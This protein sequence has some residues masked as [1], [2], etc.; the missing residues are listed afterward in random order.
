MKYN[1]GLFGSHNSA[2]AIAVDGEVKEVVEL[3]RWVGIKNAAFAYHFPIDNPSQTL[4][5]ILN[6]FKNKYGAETYNTVAFN[7]DNDLH[8]IIKANNYQ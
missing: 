8:K 2:I 5:E 4:I 6:Y 1:L 7:S 3:E